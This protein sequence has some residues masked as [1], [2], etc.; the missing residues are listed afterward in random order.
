MRSKKAGTSLAAMLAAVLTAGCCHPQITACPAGK[1]N[2]DQF[3]DGIPFYL[4]KPLLVIAKNFRNIEE[5][6]VGQM[7]AVPIPDN[8][9]AQGGYGTVNATMNVS[10]PA[11]AKDAAAP[12]AN[13]SAELGRYSDRGAPVVPGALPHDEIVTP[14]VFYT[15]H[16]LFVPDLAQKYVLRIKGGP[17][18]IRAAMNLVNGWQFTGLGPFYMKDSSTAQN[19]LASGIAANLGLRG[20]GDVIN[21]IADLRS[22]AATGRNEVGQFAGQAAQLVQTIRRFCPSPIEIPNYAEIH[23][24]EPE[25]QPDGTTRWVAVVNDVFSRTILGTISEDLVY[26]PATGQK[27]DASQPIK[28]RTN[29]VKE[30]KSSSPSP[31]NRAVPTQPMLPRPTPSPMQQTAPVDRETDKGSPLPSPRPI[32]PS[33]LRPTTQPNLGGPILPGAPANE[34]ALRRTSWSTPTIQAPSPAQ[35][36]LLAPAEQ[37]RLNANQLRNVVRLPAAASATRPAVPR[38]DD[39]AARLAA[40]E[41]ERIVG[42]HARLRERYTAQAL[43]LPPVVSPAPVVPLGPR[44]EAGPIGGPPAL[45]PAT[46][47]N[48]VINNQSRSCNEK[49]KRRLFAW[50]HRHQVKNQLVLGASEL[51]VAS[52][53]IVP[54]LIQGQQPSTTTDLK[55]GSIENDRPTLPP[56][57]MQ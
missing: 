30:P 27:S 13:E 49:K 28:P 2:C 23:V 55:G 38:P 47:T 35:G 29:G 43:G 8:F 20:V 15:Y 37:R 31:L 10:P 21:S 48:I 44:T 36:Y 19:I 25:L 41:T 33:P 45:A 57:G 7:G 9:D 18:E 52:R 12:G 40:S 56:A 50:C 39:A 5:A 54:P 32:S 53:T 14:Q 24:Y 22:K 3:C 34:S 4:P 6:K 17:G 11:A 46:G 16:I 1:F 51:E 42:T 26:Q